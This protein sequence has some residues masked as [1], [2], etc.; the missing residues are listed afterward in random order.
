[1][2]VEYVRSGGKKRVAIKNGNKIFTGGKK[3]GV[4]VALPID[5][6]I[7][8]VSWAKCHKRLDKFSELGVNIA[9]DRAVK[10][11]YHL[12]PRSMEKKIRGF[13]ERVKKYYKDKEVVEIFE[14]A[15][16]APIDIKVQAE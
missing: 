11:R 8:R 7:V 9:K 15:A 10:E 16:R 5:D 13:V 14:I 6:K 12:V 4:M 2:I 3:V 1:M